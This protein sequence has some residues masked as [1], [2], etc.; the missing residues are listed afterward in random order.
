MVTYWH[1]QNSGDFDLSG[2]GTSSSK[3]LARWLLYWVLNLNFLPQWMQLYF[4]L[5]GTWVHW[6]DS[7]FCLSLFWYVQISHLY[8]MLVY[9]FTWRFRSSVFLKDRSQF[10]PYND[11]WPLCDEWFYV[12][13]ICSRKEN[14]DHIGRIQS[15]C[16]CAHT[17]AYPKR[18]M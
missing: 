7:V 15:P 4:S 3:P 16:L 13:L 9:W 8:Q 11:L 6:W 17:C 14:F 18:Y 10:L 12:V 5:P 1:S 2:L